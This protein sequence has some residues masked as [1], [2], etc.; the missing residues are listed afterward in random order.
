VGFDPRI[1][2]YEEYERSWR[3]AQREHGQH[4]KQAIARLP[5][6]QPFVAG[7]HPTAESI[8]SL[9]KKRWFQ[10]RVFDIYLWD[11]GWMANNS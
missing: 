3:T 6:V 11:R 2:D 10:D 8:S 7:W 1:R 9:G 4:I 5:M